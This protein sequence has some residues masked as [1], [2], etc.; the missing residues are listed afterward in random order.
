T[1]KKENLMSIL[2]AFG[3]S[4]ETIVFPTH[5]RTK[6]AIGDSRSSLERRA[7]S[8]LLAISKWSNIKLIDPVGYLDSLMLQKNAKKVLTDSGGVQKEAYM[9]NVPCITL[10][11]ETEWIETVKDGWNKLVGA[12]KEQ[13]IRAIKYFLP[14]RPQHNYFG[15]GDASDKI[16]K[17]L[18]NFER[19][20]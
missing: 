13:I 8:D 5:P 20:N 18:K 6:K 16:I 2:E 17:I 9:L 15:S 3:E 11:R 1:D 7:R 12:D 4:G 14:K 10:R 19:S